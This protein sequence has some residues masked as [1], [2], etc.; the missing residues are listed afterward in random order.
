MTV[1]FTKAGNLRALCAVDNNRDKSK[2]RQW[3]NVS[4]KGATDH[5]PS[6]KRIA[7]RRKGQNHVEILTNFVNV[8]IPTVGAIC[9]N[10]EVVSIA[11]VE[12]LLNI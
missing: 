4:I 11:S 7:N 9:Y 8:E 5:L 3:R 1:Q 6:T 2:F 12:K 10:I